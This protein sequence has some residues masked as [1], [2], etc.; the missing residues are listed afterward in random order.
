VPSAALVAQAEAATVL[1]VADDGTGTGF[2][3]DPRTI[4]TNAHVVRG[5]RDGT[6]RVT[7]RRLARVLRGRVLYQ[8]S[9]DG[10]EW[11]DVALVRLEEGAAPAVVTLSP[12]VAKLDPVVAAGY[13][14]LL[15][16]SDQSVRRLLAG[17]AAAAPELVLERGTVAT[18]DRGEAN[19][20]VHSAFLAN[21]NSGGPLF[22][23]CG[24]AVGINSAILRDGR[25]GGQYNIAQDVRE[26]VRQA[27]RLSVPLRFV[28]GKCLA[29]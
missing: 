19:L 25:I 14:G 18:F 13:P 1:I 24:R 28:G 8:S 9:L 26:L 5:A 12:E 27:R 23:Q 22:D 15:S 6:V 10:R 3:I 2:F 7:S 11:P 20:I 17:D 29:G 21:G 16:H 4:A